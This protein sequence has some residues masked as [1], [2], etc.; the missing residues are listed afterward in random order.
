MVQHIEQAIEFLHAFQ[1]QFEIIMRCLQPVTPSP[2]PRNRLSLTG[3]A[4]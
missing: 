1:V 2:K 4:A 3:I